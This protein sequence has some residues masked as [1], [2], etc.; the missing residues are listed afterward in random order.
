MTKL[1]KKTAY[2]QSKKVIWTVVKGERGGP[3]D[4]QV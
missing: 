2:I 4:F 3:P 1:P